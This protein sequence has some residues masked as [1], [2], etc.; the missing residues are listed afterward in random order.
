VRGLIIGSTVMAGTFAGKLVA[1]RLS[2][3]TFEYLLDAVLFASGLSKIW[4]VFA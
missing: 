2:I 3:Q 4:E 1:Q